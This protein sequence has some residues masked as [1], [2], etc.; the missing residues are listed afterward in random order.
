[1]KPNITDTL[2]WNLTGIT[3]PMT[4]ALTAILWAISLC[5]QAQAQTNIIYTFSGTASGSLGATQFT[6][7]VF[8]IRVL[9]DTNAVV[10]DLSQPG[11]TIFEVP[12]LSSSVEVAGVGVAAF[13]TDKR[14]FVNTTAGVVGFS[15]PGIAGDLLDLVR[16]A[17]AAYN[18]EGAFRPLF[19]AGPNDG[20]GGEPSTLGTVTLSP[21]R[22]V[23]FAAA[24]T[25]PL[26][27]VALDGNSLVLQ[28]ST[29][30]PGYQLQSADSVSD[31]VSWTTVTN[32]PDIDGAQYVLTN[33]LSDAFQVYRLRN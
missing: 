23:T 26:L 10:P 25:F 6:D 8:K 33:L 2:A 28:W 27:S 13:T 22:D 3:L 9:A 24:L 29:N 7:A 5:V 17:F 1:M 32:T 11:Y 12:A 20:F 31:L 15:L 14:V 18:L 16:P 21:I 30:S 4:L 19:V